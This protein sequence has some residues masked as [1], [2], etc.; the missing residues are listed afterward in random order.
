MYMTLL[1]SWL[2]TALCEKH[3]IFNTL[4][5]LLTRCMPVIIANVAGHALLAILCA[6]MVESKVSTQVQQNVAIK[7]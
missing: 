3:E 6:L 2:H 7:G 4:G 1:V 5:F